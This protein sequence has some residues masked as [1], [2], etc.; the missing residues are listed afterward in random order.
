MA[1]IAPPSVSLS[2]QEGGD[3]DNDESNKNELNRQ[4]I[5]ILHNH[6]D[7]NDS[8]YKMRQQ[9]LSRTTYNAMASYLR[10]FGVGIRDCNNDGALQMKRIRALQGFLNNSHNNNNNNNIEIGMPATQE[11][12]LQIRTALSKTMTQAFTGAAKQGDFR[13]IRHLVDAALTFGANFSTGPSSVLSPRLFGDALIGLSK[14]PANA[15]KVKQLWKLAVKSESLLYEP[16]GTFELNAMVRAL[17]K[18]GKVHAA[19]EVTRGSTVDRRIVMDSYTMTALLDMLRQSITD[20]S[21]GKGKRRDS[22]NDENDNNEKGADDNSIEMNAQQQCWQWQVAMQL[23]DE[24]IANNNNNDSNSDD[25]G[26]NDSNTVLSKVFNNHVFASALQLNERVAQ[27][28]TQ[29]NGGKHALELLQWMEDLGISPDNVVCT[30]VLSALGKQ[31]MWREAVRLLEAMEE[32]TQDVPPNTDSMTLSTTAWKLPSPNQFA[33]SS[34]IAAC[35]RS[36]RPNTALEILNRMEAMPD[37]KTNVYV[38]NARTHTRST[39]ARAHRRT[40]EQ[41]SATRAGTHAPARNINEHDNGSHS[42]FWNDS[43]HT[44]SNRT[45]SRSTRC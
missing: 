4:Q 5:G 6:K 28:N 38:L 39:R 44:E 36:A 21:D 7:E 25:D 43:V 34:A 42:L 2:L 16:L 23:M 18:L 33:Y 9:S 27:V 24:Q 20:R 1:T 13:I 41:M 30:L 26:D 8:H 37:L 19:M 10:D 15:S 14:T 11:E 3:D 31:K 29:H 12:T 17:G 40:Y 22:S 35:A 32:E 45:K